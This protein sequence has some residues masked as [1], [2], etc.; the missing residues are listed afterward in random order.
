MKRRSGDALRRET[1]GSGGSGGEAARRRRIAAGAACNRQRR[2]K[3]PAVK[4]AGN[5]SLLI[6]IRIAIKFVYKADMRRL[7]NTLRACE[8]R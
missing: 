7:V 4:T 6:K 1:A 2:K 8:C 5:I 3:F